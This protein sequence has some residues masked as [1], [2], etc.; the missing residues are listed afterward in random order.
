MSCRHHPQELQRNGGSSDA[1]VAD[2]DAAKAA[3]QE[4]QARLAAADQQS[5]E[6]ETALA[7]ALDEQERLRTER[8][9]AR[10]VR[11]QF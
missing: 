5:G 11:W 8:D 7:A 2:R 3:L 4:A 1:V 9:D 6:L 10:R